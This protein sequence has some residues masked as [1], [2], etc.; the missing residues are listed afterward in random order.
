MSVRE[1][2]KGTKIKITLNA[3][4]DDNNNRIKKYK[5][6]DTVRPETENEVLFNIAKGIASLQ[7]HSITSIVKHVEHTLL[8]E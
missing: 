4:L 6:L 5:T 8:E 7:K 1:F 3:G 2:H